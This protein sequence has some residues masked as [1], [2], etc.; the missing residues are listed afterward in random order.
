MSQIDTLLHKAKLLQEAAEALT[1][2]AKLAELE[3]K[4][5]SCCA[6]CDSGGD[7]CCSSHD[8]DPPRHDE[9]S[10]NDVEKA[11]GVAWKLA[12]NFRPVRK[13]NFQGLDI[14]VE[15]DKGMVREWVDGATGEKGQTKMSYPYGYI[16]RTEGADG[17]QV[18]VYVGPNEDSDKVYI[19]HQMKAPKFDR[20]DEDKTMVG[21]TSAKEAKAAYLAHYNDDRFFGTMTVTTVDDFKR[22]FI[23]KSIE[24][25]KAWE[26]ARTEYIEKGITD[27]FQ[28]LWNRIKQV[29]AKDQNKPTKMWVRNSDDHCKTGVCERLHGTVVPI[30]STFT[31]MKGMQI[32]GPPGHTFC[33][34]GLYFE[35]GGVDKALPPTPGMPMAPMMPMANPMMGMGMPM[36]DPHDVET[37][38]GVQSLIGRV[39]S[40]KDQELMEIASK[41][42]GNG[43][44]FEG[45]SP[46]QAR[47][48]IL[49]FL[50]DQRDLLGVAPPEIEMPITEQSQNS[51][52][53][54]PPGSLDFSNQSQTLEEPL[55]GAPEVS[56]S[57]EESSPELSNF[58]ST[59]NSLEKPKTK[60]ESDDTN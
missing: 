49:G 45:Q 18:D 59:L 1:K 34:C 52:D 13:I 41:I 14:S 36:I 16:C 3:E 56:S 46:N 37:F 9:P 8:H 47:A 42:W 21:F 48:E 19:V 2:A 30:D 53:S 44:N 39:G 54:Q 28:K 10:I 32:D 12:K 31:A 15:H 35:P 17:E 38:E 29:F 43:Y 25:T 6:S 57:A 27:G 33:K 50:Y 26:A 40:V 24:V 60:P 20:Y 58:L 7:S 23:N 55:E 22:M 4:P 11:I 5:E 51:P